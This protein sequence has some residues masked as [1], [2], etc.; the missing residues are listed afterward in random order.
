MA[1]GAYNPKYKLRGGETMKQILE[2]TFGVEPMGW[3]RPVNVAEI[4]ARWH[5]EELK[6]FRCSWQ[7][8]YRLSEKLRSQGYIIYNIKEVKA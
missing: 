6:T 5:G 2:R 1:A 7:N 4:T 3:V 8:R